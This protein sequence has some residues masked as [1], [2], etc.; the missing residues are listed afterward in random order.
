MALI[1]NGLKTDMEKSNITNFDITYI[2]K[3]I[4]SVSI[5]QCVQIRILLPNQCFKKTSLLLEIKGQEICNLA[6]VAAVCNITNF[7]ETVV[8]LECYDLDCTQ[9]VI[10]TS[11]LFDIILLPVFFQILEFP[12]TE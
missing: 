10:I 4:Y 2:R 1:A 5:L 11:N 7:Q 6:T 9:L 8:S 3:D 12:F